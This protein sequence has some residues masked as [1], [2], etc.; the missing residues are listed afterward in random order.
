MSFNSSSIVWVSI[1]E[2]IHDIL[3]SKVPISVFDEVNAMESTGVAVL[4][5]NS[6][7]IEPQGLGASEKNLL[8][9]IDVLYSKKKKFGRT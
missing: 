7:Y 1:G 2:F 6:N 8:Y 9:N 3:Q 4:G 5:L